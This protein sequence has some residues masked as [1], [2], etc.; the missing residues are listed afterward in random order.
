[1]TRRIAA[2]TAVLSFV[3]AGSSS[4]AITFPDFSNNDP[5]YCAAA[6]KAHGHVGEID[7]VNQGLGFID[8]TFQRMAADAKAHGLNIGGYDFD[9]EY[10]ARE[11][12]TLVK[13]LHRAGIYRSTLHTFPPT[14]DIEFGLASRAGLEH[15]LAV[16]FREYGRAQIYTGSWYWLPHFGCWIPPK[17]D[18][19]ISGY[20]IASLLCGLPGNRWTVHQFT[21]H[22]PTGAAEQPAADMSVWLKDAKWFA[23]YVQAGPKSVSRVSKV[24]SLHAHE[25]DR[26]LLHGDVDRHHCRRGQ[27]VT[28][29]EPLS[30]RRHL[31]NELCPRWIKRG[32]TDIKVINR[33]HREGLK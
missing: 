26:R 28:P 7:K 1:M 6:L 4:A 20:P 33:Y 2:L 3:I 13:A 15:Q 23:S 12:Y 14:L 32:G 8:G 5:C 29:R 19:W 17:V 25:R 11:A 22:G 21:D 24:K 30:T 16:L 9:Q 18:F 27:H 31:H 10:T